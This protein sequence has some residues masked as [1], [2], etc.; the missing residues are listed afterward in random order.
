MGGETALTFVIPVAPYHQ[1][2]IPRAVEQ[3]TAQ[4][5]RCD[6]VVIVDHDRRGAGWARN[7]GVE[8]AQTPL[9]TFLDADDLLDVR[10]AER[11]VGAWRPRRYVYCDWINALGE[12]LH[13]GDCLRMETDANHPVVNCVLSKRM[14]Q[15][16]GGFPEDR[17]LE[18]TWFWAKAHFH[19]VCGLYVPE[20]LMTYT[21]EGQRAATARSVPGWGREYWSVFERWPNVGCGCGGEKAMTNEIGAHLEGDVLA[22]PLWGGNRRVMGTVSGRVYRTGNYMPT[23]VDPRD[24]T[25]QPLLWR[26]VESAPE[27]TA[28]DEVLTLAAS[29]L[30]AESDDEVQIKVTPKSQQSPDE[31]VDIPVKRT[32]KPR[33]GTK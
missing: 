31:G 21:N 13:I 8:Q 12:R 3:V 24:A 32:R 6:H 25:A 30:D 28:I 23:W 14:F 1:H 29:A 19:G 18:D 26:L 22:I 7:R 20:P 11:M 17:N 2:L 5:M 27:D 15:W 10:F 33:K 16:L 9:I 4:T